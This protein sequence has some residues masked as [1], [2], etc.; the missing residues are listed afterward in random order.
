MPDRELDP[1][2]RPLAAMRVTDFGAAPDAALIG[3]VSDHGILTPLT[4]VAMPDG[5]YNVVD[6]R[7]R[8]LAAKA[9]GMEFVPV[10]VIG[11][12][13]DAP[14]D[15]IVTLTLN[16]IRRSNPWSE[17]Q[18]IRKLRDE[19]MTLEGI[20][21]VTHW[22]IQ[23]IRRRL[24]YDRLVQEA[25]NR[26]AVGAIGPAAAERLAR[27]SEDQQTALIEECDEQGLAVT[28]NR[29]AAARHNAQMDA[30]DDLL[31][32]AAITP[33]RHDDN[34]LLARYQQALSRVLRMID[35]D[36][37]TLILAEYGVSILSDRPQP[38]TDDE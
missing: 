31:S 9:A 6:G 15:P 12:H 35:P 28:L 29:V 1:I 30:A 14:Y 24:L 7:R 23:S 25:K 8:Y 21:K 37:A 3:S 32:D 5:S 33:E 26:V 16:G 11:P 17:Y 20:G 34:N 19:G 38:D 2:M 4:V 22:P 10:R 27:L 13:P 18:A 36:E